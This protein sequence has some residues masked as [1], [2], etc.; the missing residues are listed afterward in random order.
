MSEILAARNFS[1]PSKPS[2]D[3][4]LT[5]LSWIAMSAAS[6]RSERAI[7]LFKGE[8]VLDGRPDRLLRDD[9]LVQ[10]YIGL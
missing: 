7:V 8:I 3:P 1:A 4:A 10:R 6:P 5:S 9:A 2:V